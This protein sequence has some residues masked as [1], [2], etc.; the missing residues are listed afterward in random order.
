VAEVDLGRELGEEVRPAVFAQREEVQDLA[1][2]S[3]I[4][5]D[6]SSRLLPA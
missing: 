2:M 1:S 4:P 5:A 3:G 6:S